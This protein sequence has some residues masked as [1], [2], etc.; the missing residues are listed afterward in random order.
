MSKKSDGGGIAVGGGT[1]AGLG[2][3]FFLLE[4]SPL[5]FLGSILVGLGLGL[6]IEALISRKK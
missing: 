2:V 4:T 3:G 6:L 5:F 1:L